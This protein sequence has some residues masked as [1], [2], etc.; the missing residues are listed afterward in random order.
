MNRKSNFL[1]KQCFYRNND[2]FCGIDTTRVRVLSFGIDTIV[3]PLVY[4]TAN[5]TLFEVGPE[6]RC[7]GV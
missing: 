1:N 2:M 3:L 4:C 5:V 7:S 6:I